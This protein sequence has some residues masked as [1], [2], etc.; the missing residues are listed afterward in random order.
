MSSPPSTPPPLRIGVLFEDV[1]IADLIGLDIFVN[2]SRKTL[3]TFAPTLPALALLQPLSRPTTFHYTASS[4][5]PTWTTNE[6]HVQPTHTYASAPRDFDVLLVGG[7]NPATVKPESLQYLREA[8]TQTKVVLTTCTG[9]M[10]LALSGA[11]GGRKAT[12]NRGFLPAAREMCP[13]VEWVEKRWVV[14]PGHFEGAEI[15]TAGGAGCG[16]FSLFSFSCVWYAVF[17]GI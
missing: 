6:M 16:E 7:P 8:V 2:M 12:T 15:W 5:T 11:L 14:A 1:Q 9:G 10:W 4:L 3:D 13:E 17:L